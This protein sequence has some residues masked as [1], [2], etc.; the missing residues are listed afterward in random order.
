M[1]ELR[2]TPILPVGIGSDNWSL[3]PK[4]ITF[5]MGAVPMMEWIMLNNYVEDGVMVK[6][7]APEHAAR[8]RGTRAPAPAVGAPGEDRKC[9]LLPRLDRSP[10]SSRRSKREAAPQKMLKMKSGLDGLLK[11]KG[12]KKCSG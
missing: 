12:L 7:R 9:Q 3:L 2:A 10:T 6:L 1:Q 4:Y 5:P 8:R 11:T